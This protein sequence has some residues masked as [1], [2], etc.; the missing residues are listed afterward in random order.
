[1]NSINSVNH[2]NSVITL[3]RGATSI[4]DGTF[5]FLPVQPLFG[6]GWDRYKE[7]GWDIYKEKRWDRYKEKAAWLHYS[8]AL[9]LKEEKLTYSR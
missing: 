3:K 1:M 4:S 5:Y 6:G 9:C 2:V 8:T 7:R